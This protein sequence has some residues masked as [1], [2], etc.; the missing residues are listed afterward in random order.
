MSSSNSVRL[1]FIEETTYGETPAAGN[2][3]TARFTSES[4]SGT[5]NT[6]ESQQ[7]RTDRLSSG[8]VLVGLGVQGTMNFELAKESAIDS[9]MES[10]MH[11]AWDVVATDTVDLSINATL[12][13]ITRASGSFSLAV[14][15]FITLS[16]FV[17]PANNVQVMVKALISATVIE[18][19]GPTLATEVGTG[20]ALKRA[21][22]L[23]VGTTKKSF[24]IEK[25]FLDLTDKAII[26]KGM[27]ASNMDLNFSYGQLATGSFQFSGNSHATADAAAEFITDGRTIDAP[28]TSQTLNGSVDMPFLASSALGALSTS[29]FDLQSV[30]LS[31]NNNL[32]AQNIIGEMAPINYSSGTAQIQLTLSAYVTDAM[33]SVL[34][35]KI[36]QEAFSLAFQVKN[37][38][39]W[40]AFYIPSAQITFDD[41]ASGG[42]NQ[43]IVISMTGTAKVGANGE[44]SLTVYR[45]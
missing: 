9:F 11:S 37:A 16:G 15:D 8:Q 40:Y 25:A 5:P 14:G 10:A 38:D 39:G 3:S 28:A 34:G 13:R 42:Q 29:G 17:D 2:F 26:Y 4:L 20:T 21:D 45:G 23:S 22:K 27:I 31:L 41:P 7:I 36:T 19:V 43:D 18:Y 12:K 32:T 1:A 44:S 24:S 33:W 35:K 6:V 30:A